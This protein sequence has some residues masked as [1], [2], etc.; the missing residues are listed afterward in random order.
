MSVLSLAAGKALETIRTR[1]NL[2]ARLPWLHESR[3][4]DGLL[5]TPHDL[6]TGDATI[7][8]DLYRGTFSL[9]GKRIDIGAHSPFA[10]RPP[11]RDWRE[12]LEGFSWLRHLSAANNDISRLHARS[13][14]A[15]WIESRNN[16]S[17]T[18]APAKIR[19]RRLI[20]WIS[21]APVFLD[22]AEPDFYRSAMRSFGQQIHVLNHAL[23]TT[24]DGESRLM[25]AI[26]LCFAALCLSGQDRLFAKSIKLLE[27]EIEWQILADGGHIS[28][29]P[30]IILSLL[31]DL[32]PLQRTFS[33]RDMAAPEA[34]HRAI[35]RMM[36]MIRFF[37]HGD[38]SF[39]LF[40]G[41]G[42]TKPGEAAAVL[43][44]DDVRGQ[45]IHNAQHSGYQRLEG[46]KTLIIQDA[47]APP[48]LPQSGAAHAG[49]LSF[50]LSSGLQR[51]IVNCGAPTALGEHWRQAARAT[52]A[53]S[54]ITLDE[55][56]SA[57]FLSGRLAAL[58]GPLLIS[59]PSQVHVAREEFGSETVVETSHDGYV[60]SHGVM[61]VR[62]VSLSRAGGKLDGEDRLTRATASRPFSMHRKQ[63]A[64]VRFHLHPLVTA[65]LSRD[66]KAVNLILAN[67]ERWQFS[68]VGGA[69]KLED[70]VF[71]AG[72]QGKTST[73]QI[74]IQLE[75]ETEVM[76]KWSLQRIMA[77]HA[78]T[79][80]TGNREKS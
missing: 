60:K 68:A 16:R 45:P 74:V 50:E 48:P 19:A 54:T 30:G 27:K 63:H 23:N 52:A 22:N 62:R 49:C 65:E 29:Q 80:R 6:R 24:R 11:S 44:L 66:G 26:A 15:D 69:V 47:G 38:G 73:R 59:G 42:Q 72:P 39:A 10:V 67:Q 1:L 8:G 13:L 33:A 43:A 7:A 79:A 78:D 35:D 37:R 9:G 46:G 51:I 75:F 58:L 53:H 31:L 55:T 76:L 70:S 71:L 14:V 64:A 34:L 4:P 57:H 2:T 12:E 3:T 28:R 17:T 61:H 36:P 18:A 25:A 32:L 5:L 21:H 56:S 41:M 40:N 77:G 20:S